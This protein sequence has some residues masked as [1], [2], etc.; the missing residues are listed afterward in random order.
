MEFSLIIIMLKNERIREDGKIVWLFLMAIRVSQHSYNECS[1][2]FNV[3]E[4]FN[5][6]PSRLVFEEWRFCLFEI[7]VYKYYLQHLLYE[8][9]STRTTTNEYASQS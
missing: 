2:S 3:N 8:I 6:L 1:F 4:H 7:I 5:I 9:H